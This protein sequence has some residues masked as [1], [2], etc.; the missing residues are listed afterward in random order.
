M[1]CTFALHI[2]CVYHCINW[3]NIHWHHCLIFDLHTTHL[4]VYELKKWTFILYHSN[5]LTNER[6][7]NRGVARLTLYTLRI[8]WYK[9]KNTYGKNTLII[10]FKRGS[11]CLPFHG[12]TFFA[13]FQLFFVWLRSSMMLIDVS[14]RPGPDLRWGGGGVS[15]EIS[16]IHSNIPIL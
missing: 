12:S 1:S 6:C 15:S 2:R 16:G 3:R 9:Y 14:S 5:K 8:L 13:L 10:L 11:I 7:R 4:P